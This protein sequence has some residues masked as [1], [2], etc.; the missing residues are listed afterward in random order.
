MIN[1]ER[2]KDINLKNYI[3]EYITSGSTAGE[4]CLY[5]ANNLGDN[6]KLA[7]PMNW[8]QLYWTDQLE[9]VEYFDWL[10]LQAFLRWIQ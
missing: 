8:N 7:K 10:C 3:I 9:E 5:I 1:L 2:T 6:S 4:L